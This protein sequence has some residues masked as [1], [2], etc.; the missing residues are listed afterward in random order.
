MKA[1]ALPLL[2]AGLRAHAANASLIE[3]IARAFWNLSANADNKVAVVRAGTVPLIVMSIST[4]IGKSETVEAASGV[5]R[6]VSGCVEGKA[7]VVQAGGIAV[8]NSVVSRY[9]VSAGPGKAASDALKKIG[10]ISS[11]SFPRSSWRMLTHE[12]FVTLEGK[13]VRL[14]QT[15][16]FVFS[17]E[18]A[19]RGPLG[20]RGD[21]LTGTVTRPDVSDWTVRVNDK[22]S[23]Q[24]V[25]CYQFLR[26][27]STIISRK[28]VLSSVVV[29]R[30]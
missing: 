8:L 3:A 12:D 6:N 22:V 1:G 4:H 24:S 26:R 16:P 28:L 21:L 14:V 25:F 27:S 17:R 23:L 20:K 7:A 18:D 13:L 5:L 2:V 9:G 19:E 29:R 30:F 15:T 11:I 10:D